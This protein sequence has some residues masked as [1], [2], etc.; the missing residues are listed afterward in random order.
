MK[1][2][3]CSNELHEFTAGGSTVDI[4]SDGCSGIWFDRAELEQAEKDFPMELMLVNRSLS[5]VVDRSKIRNCPRCEGKAMERVVLDPETRFEIDR[6]P[7]CGGHWLDRGELLHMR[8]TA[9]ENA[10]LEARLRSYET[11]FLRRLLK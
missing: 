2:P 10:E 4:C 8:K 3:A 5:V 9:Q 6:C 11:G 7:G 1:C